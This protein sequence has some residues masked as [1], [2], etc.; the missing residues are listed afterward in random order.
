MLIN[1][2]NIILTLK[3]QQGKNCDI[4]KLKRL[5]FQISIKPKVT[6]FSHPTQIT[7]VTPNTNPAI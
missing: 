3:N 2:L 7:S 1:I 6:A 5:E 4:G